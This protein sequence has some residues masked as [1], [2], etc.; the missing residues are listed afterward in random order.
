VIVGCLTSCFHAPMIFWTSEERDLTSPFEEP[1]FLT[2]GFDQQKLQAA[3]VTHCTLDPALQEKWTESPT[4]LPNRWG[5]AVEAPVTG[6]LE[7]AFDAGLFG[8][9]SQCDGEL[10]HASWEDSRSNKG[11]RTMKVKVKSCC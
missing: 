4:S 10:H 8:L 1:D 2:S 3:L 7:K 5:I 9:E 11:E 6:R